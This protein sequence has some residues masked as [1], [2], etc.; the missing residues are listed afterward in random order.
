MGCDIH[1][2]IEYTNKKRKEENLNEGKTPYWFNFGSR[3]N[4]GRN[5]TMFA[6]LAGVRGR[7]K[8]SFE[9]KG[10][11]PVNQLGWSSR[12][13]FYIYI[14]E[15]P[16]DY[17]HSVTPEQAKKWE[18]RGY[19]IIE[20]NGKPTWV[21]NPDLHTHTWMSPDELEKA[22]EIYKVHATAEWETETD[23]P[24]EYKA[25]LSVMRTLE[26]GGENEVR[27]VFCFDN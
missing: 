1:M 11:I 4:P 13:D 5:Y 25:I 26:D 23:V 6:V 14:S 7:Y 24:I 2:Y 16:I 18:E 15:K 21:E 22:F 19:E 12:D 27:V 3:I 8:D 9:R 20:H 10:K 17:E